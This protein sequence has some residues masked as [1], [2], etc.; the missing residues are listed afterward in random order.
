[1]NRRV[2]VGSLATT[3]AWVGFATAQ[4]PPANPPAGSSSNTAVD[5]PVYVMKTAG[6]PERRVQVVKSEKLPDG[7]YLTDVKDLASGVVYTLTNPNVLGTT[8]T[9]PPAPKPTAVAAT[10]GYVPPPPPTTAPLPR[11]TPRPLFGSFPNQQQY[12]TNKTKAGERLVPAEQVPAGA[13]PQARDRKAD[14]L[15]AGA[16]TTPAAMTARTPYPAGT[17]V[18]ADSPSVLSNVFG[19]KSKD[20]PAPRVGVRPPPVAVL[21][22]PPRQAAVP[23]PEPQPTIKVAQ[24]SPVVMPSVAAATIPPIPKAEVSPVAEGLSIPSIAADA[25]PS[26]ATGIF[27]SQPAAAVEKPT[28][29]I[30]PIPTTPIPPIDAP[31]VVTAPPAVEPPPLP[32]VLPMPAVEPPPL[33]LPSVSLPPAPTGVPSGAVPVVARAVEAALPVDV[34]VMIDQLKGHKRPSFRMENAT[35]LAESAYAKHPDVLAALLHGA[36][37]DTTGVVRGHCIGQLATLRYGDAAFVQALDTWT[38]DAEPAVRRAAA[39]AK[40]TLR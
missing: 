22:E 27:D 15:L 8:T 20:L 39:A 21:P 36:M 9:P 3:A 30:P 38:A 26:A 11:G 31:P 12:A 2:W 4:A 40:K 5:G 19:Q 37:N 18:A 33:P 13:L 1:M 25:R 16:A 10:T 32:T 35:A 14:P 28:V 6:Q 29:A 24:V 7:T 34:Q 23:A 17:T